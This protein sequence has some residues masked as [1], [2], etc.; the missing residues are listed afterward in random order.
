MTPAEI[1]TE[2]KSRFGDAIAEFATPA[3]GDEYLGV[4]AEYLLEICRILKE[5]AHYSFDYLRLITAVD[6]NDRLS[7]VYHLYSY[8]HEH[9]LVL[10]V[11][12]DRSAP[13]V[14]SV[15]SIWPA[16]DWLEREAFDMMGIIYDGHPEL[17][18]ILLPLDWE[19][20]PLRKDYDFPKEYHGVKHD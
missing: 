10:R 15:N 12:T 7:S 9:C 4:K 18:R 20:H 1:H 14:P 16:A 2:L 17:S 5:E 3:A 6:W 13:R 8:T 19:G 11:D